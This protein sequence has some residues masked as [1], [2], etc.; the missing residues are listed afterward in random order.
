MPWET[1]R[2]GSFPT[3]NII[4]RDWK[5]IYEYIFNIVFRDNIS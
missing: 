3:N 4:P 5:T 2:Q 1:S